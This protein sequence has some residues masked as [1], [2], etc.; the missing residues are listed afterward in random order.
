MVSR[1]GYIALHPAFLM[2]VACYVLIRLMRY[3]EFQMPVWMNGYVTDFLCIP[4][5]LSA[6]LL[7]SRLIRKNHQLLI[8]PFMIALI[9]LEFAV[10]FEWILPAKSPVYTADKMD[11]LMYFL[12]GIAF[13]FLQPIYRP[14]TKPA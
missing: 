5:I 7:V 4:L 9:C 6:T 10:V 3:L 12:G 1:I 2:M 11:T 8:S 13:Y 14:D